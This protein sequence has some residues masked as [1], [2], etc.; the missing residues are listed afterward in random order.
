MIP[1]VM[2]SSLPALRRARRVATIVPVSM[3]TTVRRWRAG[4]RAPSPRCRTGDKRLGDTRTGAPVSLLRPGIRATDP[5]WKPHSPV[6]IRREPPWSNP[7]IPQPRP[8]ILPILIHN[9]NLTAAAT[10][11]LRESLHWKYRPRKI[12]SAGGA[13]NPQVPIRGNGAKQWQRQ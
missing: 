4:A 1:L 11:L 8:K 12:Q 9:P 2:G 7:N 10:S 5:D 13:S 6:V 3:P